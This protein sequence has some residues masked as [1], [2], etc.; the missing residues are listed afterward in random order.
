[1]KKL[2]IIIL[3]VICSGCT[4]RFKH[5]DLEIESEPIISTNDT[6]RLEA[7]DIF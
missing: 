3:L 6:Y 1:M 2:L 7:I 4:L 5:Q